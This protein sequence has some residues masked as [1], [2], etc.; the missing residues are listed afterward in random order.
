MYT[1]VYIYTRFLQPERQ[2]QKGSHSCALPATAIS[3]SSAFCLHFLE[4]RKSL[5]FHSDAGIMELYT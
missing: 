5:F 2:G 4:A 1:C 3:Y